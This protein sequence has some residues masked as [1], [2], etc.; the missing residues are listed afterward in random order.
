[1]IKTWCQKSSLRVAMLLQMVLAA[2]GPALAG[3]ELLDELQAVNDRELDSMRGGYASSGGLEISF[4]IEQAVF[5]DGILQ[6]VTT[7]NSASVA[8][9][10]PN[11]RLVGQNTGLISASGVQLVLGGVASM[12]A[13]AIRSNLIT[14][15]QNSQDN[16]II[17]NITQI[18][19]TVSSLGIYREMNLLSSLQQQLINS[20]R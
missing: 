16:T 12:D 7:F 1:M 3:P 18:N 9:N 14:V 4:G 17:D 10:L 5:I 8:G 20:R 13:E 11:S 15:V 19:A 2:A 6:A